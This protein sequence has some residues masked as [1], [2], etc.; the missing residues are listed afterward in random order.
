MNADKE[1]L[2][3]AIREKGL[4]NSLI[5]IYY[6]IGRALPFTAQR[7]PDGRVSNWYKSQYVEVHKIIPSGKGGKYG[8]ALGFYYRNGMRSNSS[9]DIS[10]SWCKFDDTEPQPV[11]CAACGSWVLLDIL[12]ESTHEPTKVYGLE[13]VLERGKHKGEKIIDVVHKD[14]SWIK[15]ANEESD[16]FFF[17]IDAV[18]EEH[19]KDVQILRAEDVLPFGKYQGRTVGEIAKENPNYLIWVNDNN[20]SVLIDFKSLMSEEDR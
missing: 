4:H 3:K 6:N 11:P 18:W 9:D 8:D 17:D 12:G 10:Y 14:W 7:F 5:S 20:E 16:C 15:W 19:I 2:I 1:I 13:D